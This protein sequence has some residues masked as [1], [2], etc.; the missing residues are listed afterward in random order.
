M[1]INM[2]Y[3]GRF[4][5]SNIEVTAGKVQGDANKKTLSSD[6]ELALTPVFYRDSEHKTVAFIQV[7][8]DNGQVARQAKLVVS[9]ATG[10]IKLQILPNGT[11]SKID[12]QDDASPE[13]DSPDGAD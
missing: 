11:T 1:R 2:I 5:V 4:D 13:D 8:L 9:G 12:Q 3:P 7:Q 10:D 6:A